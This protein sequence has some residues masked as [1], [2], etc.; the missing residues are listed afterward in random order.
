MLPSQIVQF[1]DVQLRGIE[2][3]AKHIQLNPSVCGGLNALVWLVDGIPEALLP[4]DPSAL[5]KLVRSCESIRFAVN[6]AAS[7]TLETDNRFGYSD[8]TPDGGGMPSPVRVIQQVL[9]AC[10]DQSPRRSSAELLFI[11]D[12]SERDNLLLDLEA[13]RVALSNDEF[14]AATVLAGSLVEALLLWAIQ[15]EP[16]TEIQAAAAAAFPSGNLPTDPLRW[17]L[18]Q[19]AGVA[20]EL[21]VIDS[22]TA[23]QV[24]LAKDFR[25]LIHPGLAIR[26]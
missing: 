2:N 23:Q 22:A 7:H 8:L 9:A 4:S 19:C 24:R 14:K 15:S 25:N 18:N 1:I 6:K 21:K 16:S 11:K 17:N 12:Q 3:Q 26:R 13:T 5:S 20:L 10:P